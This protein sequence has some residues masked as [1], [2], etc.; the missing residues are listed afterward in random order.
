MLPTRMPALKPC[1]ACP[2]LPLLLCTRTC[3]QRH[4][5]RIS[6]ISSSSSSKL[7]C[8]ARRLQA[9]C[10][11]HRSSHLIS[12][13]N[14]HNRCHR[15][16]PLHQWLSLGTA[17]RTHTRASTLRMSNPSIQPCLCHTRARRPTSNTHRHSSHS[18]TTPPFL[19][20]P[21]TLCTAT[22]QWTLIR[23]TSTSSTS[24]ISM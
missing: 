9:T 11:I 8:S 1:T 6:I 15:I 12:I 20:C 23:T 13:I 14:T 21:T 22:A 7:S 17:C 24:S 16:T 4:P 10:S 2:R 19:C 5:L 3:R 18:R